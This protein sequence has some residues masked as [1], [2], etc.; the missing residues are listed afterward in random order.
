M[1]RLWHPYNPDAYDGAMAPS[2][3]QAHSLVPY[4]GVTSITAVTLLAQWAN[5]GKFEPLTSS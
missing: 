5:L 2:Y 4:T 3:G 1:A